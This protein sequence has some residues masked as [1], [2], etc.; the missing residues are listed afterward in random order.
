MSQGP[1]YREHAVFIESVERF[2]G[3]EI[4]PHVDQ[5]EEQDGFPDSIFRTLGQA[6]YLGL[7]IPEQYGGAAGDY[8]LAAAWCETFGKVPSVGFTVAVNMHSLVISY[9]LAKYGSGAAKERW[10]ADAVAGRAIGAY[11]F[12]EPGAG[13]DLANIRSNA[14]RQGE[15]WILN[16]AKTF[17]TNG[18]RANFVLVLAKTDASAGYKGFTTFLVDSSL[19]GFSVN[20]TL[21]KLGWRASDTAEL[22]FSDVELDA[23]CVL[24]AVGEGWRQAVGNLNWERMMLTLTALG[25]GR[26]CYEAALRYSSERSAF[27]R[28]IGE[29]GAI[30]DYLQR[31]QQLLLL[32]EAQAHRALKLMED[33]VEC[34]FD[35]A[36]AKRLICGDMVWIADRAIQIFGGYGYTREFP[37]ERWWRDLR[38][39]PIGGGTDEIMGNIAAKEL[40]LL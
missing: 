37:A 19:P 8:R 25:G 3:A 29:F 31:M 21:D 26:A 34:R 35:V 17:I 9:A 28:S 39:M 1:F 40:Q 14:R 12:T 7:L 23:D 4:T 20:R 30:R 24:G 36:A 32:G 33:G 16:G 5:W 11:A 10:L 27:G 38:L 18:A 6:G 15:K 22:S 13:S 2:I